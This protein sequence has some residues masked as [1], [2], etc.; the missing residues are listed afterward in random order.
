MS[1]TATIATQKGDLKYINPFVQTGITETLT[2]AAAGMF[3]ASRGALILQAAQKPGD[4]ENLAFFQ[5]ISGLITRR[6]PTSLS[7]A[8]DTKL[9]Q[10]SYNRVK[11][12]RKIG[13]VASTRDAFRK[14][15][16]SRDAMDL[17]VGQQA[18]VAMQVDMVNTVIR[19]LRAALS[20]DASTYV[21][22]GAGTINTAGSNGL[23]DALAKRG[24]AASG[25]VCWIMHSK[26]FYNLVK[27]QISANIDGVSALVFSAASPLT[28]G[29]PVLVTDSPDLMVANG[30]S[31]GVDAYYTLGLTAGAALME[32]TEG[33]EV[34]T[35]DVTGQEN[36]I[37]RIQGEYA[38][39]IGLKG[40]TW[41]VTNGGENPTNAALATGTNW[42]VALA[43][44][45]DRA[46]VV[47]RTR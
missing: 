46:G 19:S 2:Q 40:Y 7:I 32:E 1:S 20:T 38:Q 30:I 33:T 9:V 43:D 27:E 22:G 8:P 10:S 5:N 25:I 13:P 42:D 39:N 15:G 36:L 31:A 23:V 29:R 44:M 37:V 21:D 35:Q 12:N 34:I 11:I 14:A 24:D 6:D 28:M 47:L 18:G 45:K 3:E 16:L 41:D 17:V 26:V 4:F